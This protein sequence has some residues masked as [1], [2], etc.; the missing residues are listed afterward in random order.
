[1][2]ECGKYLI[3]PVSKDCRD[4]LMYFADLE[5]IGDICGPLPLTQF[6][7]ELKADYDVSTNRR[8]HNNAHI[9]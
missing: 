2:S 4:S 7:F 9:Y 8:R 1:M 3:M 6:V 5:A